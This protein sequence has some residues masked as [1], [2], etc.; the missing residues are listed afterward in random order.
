MRRKKIWSDA[1]QKELYIKMTRRVLRTIR[2]CGGLDNYL[3]S[4]K[5][6]RIKELGVFGWQL[7]WQVM[8]TPK[9]QKWMRAERERLGLPRPPSFKDWLR[10]KGVNLAEEVKDGVNIEEQTKP[11]YNDKLH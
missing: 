2:K 10:L 4:D 8:Q 1:L 7:R 5:P 6:G 11:F 9:I 3:L